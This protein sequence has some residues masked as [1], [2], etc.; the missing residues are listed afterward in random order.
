MAPT[1]HWR[2]QYGEMKANDAKRLKELERENA[3]FEVISNVLFF[4]IGETGFEPATA[5]PPACMFQRC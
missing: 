2:N 4:G 5:R 1:E 3:T